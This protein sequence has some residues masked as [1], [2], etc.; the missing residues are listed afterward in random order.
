MR[1][2]GWILA[3]YVVLAS[4]GGG[5]SG[6]GSTSASGGTSNTPVTPVVPT[7]PPVTPVTPALS[8]GEI[9]PTADATYLSATM[10]LTTTGEIGSNVDSSSK[11]ATTSERSITLD[12]PQFSASYNAQT[13]YR[14]ADVAN[15]ATFSP[16]QFYRETQGDVVFTN[17]S[18]TAGDYLALYKQFVTVSSGR[19]T[20]TAAPVYGGIAGWQHTVRNGSSNRTRLD[21]FAYGPATPLTAMPRSGVVKFITN[22]SGNYA[23]D[24]QLFHTYDGGEITVDFGAGR[25]YGNISTGGDDLISGGGGGLASFTFSATING[26]TV[27]TPVT[28]GDVTISGKFH[29]LFIGPNAEEFIL[30]FVA[31][32][33]NVTYVA[34]C[35]GFRHPFQD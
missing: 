18:A 22:G 24:G 21:Y 8:T 7:T 34:A 29:M 17:T 25:V 12:T 1:G 9:K 20:A 2:K 19:G 28:T 10:E 26:N 6:G 5:G 4:C 23:S 35:I 31:Q 3:A 30:A 15:T 16:A 27:V 11:G 14:L 13:G 33:G 32:N